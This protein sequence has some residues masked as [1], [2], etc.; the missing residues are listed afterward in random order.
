MLQHLDLLFTGWGRLQQFPLLAHA[1][2]LPERH[3]CLEK[4]TPVTATSRMT[5]NRAESIFLRV[6]MLKANVKVSYENHIKRMFHN[7]VFFLLLTPNNL[8]RQV[9]LI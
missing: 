5:M 8:R 3:T 4:L 7:Y 1:A 6:I 9:F 2:D